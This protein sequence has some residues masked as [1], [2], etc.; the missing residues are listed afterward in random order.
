MEEKIILYAVLDI[1]P[2]WFCIYSLNRIRRHRRDG[3]E[4]ISRV[5]PK[6]L[7]L[8]ILITLCIG[9]FSIVQTL[10]IMAKTLTIKIFYITFTVSWFIS[11][12]MLVYEFT[13][14]LKMR[15][16][17]HR[18]FWLNSFLIW[19]LLTL[20]NFE[21]HRESF[22]QNIFLPR[23]AVFCVCA[24]MN[25]ILAVFAVF[26]P[27]EFN[28]LNSGFVKPL[29]KS[30][31][32]SIVIGQS[33]FDKVSIKIRD[34]KIKHSNHTPTVVYNICVEIE[35]N[36]HVV[37]KIYKD[38]QALESLIT[39]MFPVKNFPHLEIPSLPLFNYGKITTEEKMLQLNAYLVKICHID[40]FNE[41][42]LNFFEIDGHNKGKILSLHNQ[43]MKSADILKQT[44]S[45]DTG[46][47]DLSLINYE[48]DARTFSEYLNTKTIRNLLYVELRIDLLIE[49]DD[50][51]IYVIT[52]KCDFGERQIKKSFKDFLNL[53]AELK[54]KIS[55]KILPKLPKKSY[56][57]FIS[58]LDSKALEVKK[59]K[60][61][62]YL[63][64]LLNDPTFHTTEIF[65]F[66]GITNNY[67]GLWTL[68]QITYEIISPIE[69]ETDVSEL[70]N[71]I[72]IITIRKTVSENHSYTFQAKRNYKSIEYLHNVL[73]MRLKSP[74]LI[75]YYNHFNVEIPISWPVLPNKIA[76]ISS[77][78]NEFCGKLETYI[79]EVTKIPFIEKAYALVTFFNDI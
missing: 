50:Q 68:K 61:E 44:E 45:G 74:F 57:K 78:L 5:F 48:T 13:L 17:G 47:V 72:F 1:I 55:L 38:F 9:L 49:Y 8:K 7:I 11:T 63:I 58:N 15:W 24:G 41:D 19:T 51:V 14:K 22:M 6:P 70:E 40:F 42:I 53:H 32:N 16:T 34:F 12:I 67:K 29:I 66:I 30:A 28:S 60:L 73:I 69:W 27:D 26:R 4:H 35:G 52:S 3:K 33:F 46:Y 75:D 65:E 79:E 56:F 10:S 76:G 71:V 37:K 54:K 20:L 23:I 36:T 18:S 21:L 2:T 39:S 77:S 25:L 43:V 62:K 31:K 64:Y 59:K